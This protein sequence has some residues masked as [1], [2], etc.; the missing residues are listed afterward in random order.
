M[1]S[2]SPSPHLIKIHDLPSWYEPSHFIITGY[3]NPKHHATPAAAAASAFTWHNETLNIH[4]H[5]W[6][7]FAALYALYYR[8]QQP[9]YLTATP[10][11]QY[12]N[13]LQCLGAAAMGFSSAFAHTFYIISP[14]WY[15]FAW[16]VDCAGIVAVVYTHLLAD[17][18]LLFSIHTPSP[19]LFYTSMTAC[20]LISL[21]CLYAAFRPHTSDIVNSIGVYYGLLGSVPYTAAVVWLSPSQDL[22][23]QKMAA[24]SAACSICCIIAGGIFFTGKIPERFVQSRWIDLGLR[25]HVWHHIFISLS[26]YLG[27]LGIPYLR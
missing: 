22:A 21:V 20:T 9:Y 14:A 10:F 3:R 4:T 27:S 7:G 8:V 23:F 5:L 15:T 12:F 18:Y 16:K 24:G 17:N 1:S 19:T 6:T 11:I 26:I 25:S 2:P 13:I